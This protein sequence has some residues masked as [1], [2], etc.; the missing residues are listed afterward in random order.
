MKQI[1]ILLLCITFGVYINAQEKTL[2]PRLLFPVPDIDLVECEKLVIAANEDY[3]NYEP[4][5]ERHH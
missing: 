3:D 2:E 1:S 5:G 4:K